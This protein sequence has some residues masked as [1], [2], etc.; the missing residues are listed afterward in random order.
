MWVVLTHEPA[1]QTWGTEISTV[2]FLSDRQ[3]KKLFY[4]W[5]PCG[6]Q[7]RVESFGSGFSTANFLDSDLHTWDLHSYVAGFSEQISFIMLLNLIATFFLLQS[8][9]PNPSGSGMG[10]LPSNM[11]HPSG[12]APPP[13]PPGPPPHGQPTQ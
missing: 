1:R 7:S 12:M 3:I 13:P 6:K 8:G 2:N 4:V 11:G 10:T 9:N 5:I